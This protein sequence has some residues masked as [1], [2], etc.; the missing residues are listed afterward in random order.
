[1]YIKKF[2][3]FRPGVYE[4]QAEAVFLEHAYCVGGCR[5][6]SYTCICGTG[7]NSAVLHYG[8]AGA[9]NEKEIRDNDMCLFDMG[10]NYG[11]YASDITCSF[12]ANGKFTADQKIIY[13]AVL[14]AR[15]AVSGAAR[16]GV[17]WVDMHVLANRVML[18]EMKKANILKGDVG[19]MIDVIF[20][21]FSFS[22]IDKINVIFYIF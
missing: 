19:E 5:H 6:V 12:P 15:D 4:Y 22:L 16:D 9:P 21:I 18:E 3:Y 13:N 10:A 8:H 20:Y 7:T 17:S 11:G 2:L 14:A 1:M